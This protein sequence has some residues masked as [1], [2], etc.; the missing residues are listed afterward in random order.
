MK[1][2]D[3]IIV[4]AGTAGSLAAKTV[5]K[6]GLTTLILDSKP[7]DQI[8][9]KVCGDVIGDHHFKELGITDPHNGAFKNQVKGIKVYSPDEET[10]FTV[11]NQDFMGFML[12]RQRFGQW[13]LDEAIETGAELCD[14]TMF[15][16]PV[17]DNGAVRGVVA[18]DSSGK[19]VTLES[20]VVVDAS[21]FFG[22][23]RNKL[24]VSMGIEGKLANEDVE[25]CYREVRQ[26]EQPIEDTDYCHIILNQ[27]NTPG[28]YT[29]V[30]PLEDAQVNLGLGI[31]MEGN[32]PSPKEV[33]YKHLIPKPMFKG[34]TI[35]K[36]GGGFD[37]TRRPIDK[38]VGNGVVLTGDAA[39]LVNPVH[40]GGIGPSMKSGYFAGKAI[41]EALG[42]GEATEE[43]LWSY[44][45]D[46][47]KDY[48]KK[49]ASLDVFRR[50]LIATDDT[51]LNYG[52]KYQLLTQEDIYNAGMGEEFDSN[53]TDTAMRVFR[54]ISKLHFLKKL[55]L[56]VKLM[57]DM[58]AHYSLYPES[59]ADFDPW[60][61]K[62]VELIDEARSSLQ[63]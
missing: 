6:A 36:M 16:E 51:D 35:I 24:P 49:Q 25:L 33:F 47:M 57:K 56:T 43:N 4:G 19:R 45:S 26:L 54:G 46:F 48:G 27:K 18:K 40:G 41:I 32:Y 63:H 58:R 34:S 10:V 53:I 7:R 30:F 9:N 61:V 42:K 55:S 2:Y 3:V 62:T 23:V 50:F 37:P 15:M 17:I 52:M 13:L 22:V 11:A 44:P 29:W 59:P 12:N 60:R 8:G 1:K 38:L 5:A 39:S 28:G 20:K 14:S 21:G 31:Y